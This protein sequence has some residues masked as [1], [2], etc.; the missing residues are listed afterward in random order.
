MTKKDAFITIVKNEIF[1]N[2][3]TYMENYPELYED[4]K[5]Y[6]DVLSNG[7]AAT[8]KPKFTLIG[9][10]VLAFMQE[11]KDKYNNLFTAKGMSEELNVASRS[12][13]G[14][15]RKLV[16]D[17]YLEKLGDNPVTYALTEI[18]VTANLDNEEKI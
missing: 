3:T 8:D 7:S 4:A 16:N 17:G 11:N 15:C 18:G 9:A 2:P 10:K 13:S 12:I 6:F 1:D 14:G 5:I